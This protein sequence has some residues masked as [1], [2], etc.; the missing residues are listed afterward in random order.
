[1]QFQCL[2]R[3]LKLEGKNEKKIACYF[4]KCL[5][6]FQVSLF[7]LSNDITSTVLVFKKNWI[8]ILLF[9]V[10]VGLVVLGI[11]QIKVCRLLMSRICY[12]WNV[13]NFN[14]MELNHPISVFREIL[15]QVHLM[16]FLPTWLLFCV[17]HLVPLKSLPIYVKISANFVLLL[18]LQA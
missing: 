8:F 6:N 12:V 15:F 10:N 16:N 9:N 5:L 17:T 2:S 11:K 7:I 18:A 3:Y 4:K 13:Q 1:M 14:H